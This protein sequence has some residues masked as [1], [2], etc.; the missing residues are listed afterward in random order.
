M[1]PEY[2]IVVFIF[3]TNPYK[4]TLYISK[5]FMLDKMT[6][7]FAIFLEYQKK[8]T[9]NVVFSFHVTVFF[10]PKKCPLSTKVYIYVKKRIFQNYG[11][12][13]SRTK[14]LF[15]KSNI[16]HMHPSNVLML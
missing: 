4:Y 2:V 3:V 6:Q 1:L 15:P 8:N 7:N 12:I 16:L 9:I 5:R 11:K 13:S 10:P 14:L